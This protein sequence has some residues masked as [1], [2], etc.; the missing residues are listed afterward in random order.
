MTS[1]RASSSVSPSTLKKF[2]E[3]TT[4]LL[5]EYRDYRHHLEKVDKIF[6]FPRYGTHEQLY[7]YVSNDI[8]RLENLQEILKRSGVNINHHTKDYI[9]TVLAGDV[10]MF[11]PVSSADT[12]GKKLTSLQKYKLLENEE[13]EQ[14]RLA[15]AKV[16]KTNPIFQ[17]Y[18]HDHIASITEHP[19]RITRQKLFDIF[20]N[21]DPKTQRGGCRCKRKK[22]VKANA[23]AKPNTTKKK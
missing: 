22:K 12:R 1:P 21:E 6:T 20:E 10:N 9:N 5:Q 23:K 19:S 7:R 11:L 15:A 8:T 13:R 18:R 2:K 3:K 16:I 14:L 4:K 17:R